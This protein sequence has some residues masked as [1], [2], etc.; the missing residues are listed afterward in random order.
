MLELCAWFAF[1]ALSNLSP[2]LLAG[3]TPTKGWVCP[4]DVGV[5]GITGV[6][7]L[8]GLNSPQDSRLRHTPHALLLLLFSVCTVP[9]GLGQSCQFRSKDK[10]HL[11]GAWVFLGP[12]ATA[13]N[14]TDH[15]CFLPLWKETDTDKKGNPFGE[16]T[17]KKYRREAVG[18]H[19]IRVLREVRKPVCGLVNSQYTDREGAWPS[20]GALRP[21]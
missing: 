12:V 21:L 6:Q 7:P 14:K 17:A 3:C 2:S 9:S 11:L 15:V 10:E 19:L 20:S 8:L 5:S 18:R 13:V 1:F 4:S 16:M